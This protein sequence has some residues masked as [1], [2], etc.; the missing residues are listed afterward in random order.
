M[1]SNEKQISLKKYRSRNG[2]SDKRKVLLIL[3]III[4]IAGCA[5]AKYINS[6]RHQA[7]MESSRFHISSDY[8][9]DGG[10]TYD[11]ANW[12][13]GFDILLYNY[14]KENIAQISGVDMTYTVTAEN[15]TVE[16]QDEG[17]KPV[18]ANGDKYLFEKN[19]DTTHHVLHVTPS[20]SAGKANDISVT[21]NTKSPYKKELKAVFDIQKDINPDYKIADQNN[22][23]VLITVKTN[24]Y[25]GRMTVEWNQDKYS[26]DN[27]NVLMAGW[28]DSNHAGSF[29]V[30]RNSTYELLF[31]K[32]NDGNYLPT[33]GNGKDIK[34]Q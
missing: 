7:E 2:R 31:F 6:T 13:D 12:E 33:E 16:V 23:T 24:G 25:Q 5:L 15:A 20:V 9:E 32:N 3:C 4:L 1:Q 14:E 22:G 27:T 18:A 17:G 8:L 28:K 11:I 34:L 26:P 29:D 10:V 30:E 21:V 19:A